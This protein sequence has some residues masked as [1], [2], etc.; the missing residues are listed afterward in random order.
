MS[1]FEAGGIG[2]TGPTGA[3]GA[4]GATGPTSLAA[5]PSSD[6]SYS[7]FTSTLTAGE[8]L[9]FGDPVYI[10]S[11]GKVWKADANGSSTYPCMGMAT[12]TISADASGVIL[13]FG[14]AR[15]DA[16]SWTV[17]GVIYLSTAA[18]L[19]QTQPSATDEVIQ[20]LGIA[21]HADRLLFNPS[22]DYMTHT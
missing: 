7:G 14:F 22:V 19:T 1:A 10:K 8:N 9:A 21:S 18:G 13:L 11:D 20:V 6:V 2:P 3:T 4:T 15:N 17:G 16:W 5:A 12:E